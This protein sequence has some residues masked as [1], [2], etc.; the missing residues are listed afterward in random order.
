MLQLQWC[1]DERAAGG[2][3]VLIL[4]LQDLESHKAEFKQNARAQSVTNSELE[5]KYPE[6][7][8]PVMNCSVDLA[9]P[10]WWCWRC[11]SIL[12]IMNLVF[13]MCSCNLWRIHQVSVS[14]FEEKKNTHLGL[15][16]RYIENN[17]QSVSL[18]AL[19]WCWL[20]DLSSVFLDLVVILSMVCCCT[21]DIDILYNL[22]NAYVAP[23]NKRFKELYIQ[24]QY[25]LHFQAAEW[26][27][28]VLL[29]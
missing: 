10:S 5:K 14:V 6:A 1:N 20:M 29:S 22:W 26:L 9:F 13:Y 2:A 11:Y 8:I 18:S 17:Q 15:N 4:S 19:L 25:I 28:F 23:I 24:L 16:H 12:W 27:S 21:S 3:C 7:I